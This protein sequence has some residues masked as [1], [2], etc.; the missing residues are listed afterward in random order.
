MTDEDD[1]G[2]AAAR[3]MRRYLDIKIRYHDKDGTPITMRRW[4]ELRTPEYSIVGRDK[5]GPYD[6]VTAWLGLD[7]NFRA[8]GRPLIFE[9]EVYI[10]PVDDD[11]PAS[12]L[13]MSRERYYTLDGAQA[14]H[15]RATAQAREWVAHGRPELPPA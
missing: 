12:R 4:V 1:T 5:I 13:W 8:K 7:Y 9:T 11:E 2:D 14:G 3:W 15:D 6:V 10:D